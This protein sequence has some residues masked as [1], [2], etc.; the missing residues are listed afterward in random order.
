MVDVS[1]I[2]KIPGWEKN[3]VDESMYE[4]HRELAEDEANERYEAFILVIRRTAD[5]AYSVSINVSLTDS[6][7][8]DLL[9]AKYSNTYESLEEAMYNGYE[10]TREVEEEFNLD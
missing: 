1:D 6:N 7:V 9:N 5:N 10:F 2:K 3:K 4:W 8:G